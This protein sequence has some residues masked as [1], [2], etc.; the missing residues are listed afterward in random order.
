MVMMLMGM[1]TEMEIVRW[2]RRDGKI[3]LFCGR[4]WRRHKHGVG[5]TGGFQSASEHAR[6]GHFVRELGF[7]DSSIPDRGL[8][9]Q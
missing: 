7:M 6:T 5:A 9:T 3:E 4:P 2:P 1:E 8:R